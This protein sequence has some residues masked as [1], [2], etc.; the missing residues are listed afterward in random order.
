MTMS[1]GNAYLHELMLHAKQF[2]E[3]NDI[4]N[5]AKLLRRIARSAPDWWE[6]HAELAELYKKQGE[7]KAMLHFAKRSV[8]LHASNPAAWRNL[9]IAATA[10]KKNRIAQ[11]V[12]NKFGI[13]AGKADPRALITL[14]VPSG[15]RFEI[16]WAHPLD[17][18]RAVITSIPQPVSGRRYHDV[19]LFDFEPCGYTVNG[20]KRYAVFDQ[21]G[22]YRH[23]PYKTFSCTVDTTDKKTLRTLERLCREGGLGFENWTNAARVM[24]F[25]SENALP[26]FYGADILPASSGSESVIALAA[27]NQKDAE[28]V[29]RDWSVIT[30]AN[31]SGFQRL[32]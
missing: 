23:S 16:L 30:L 29:L 11:T 15:R 22:L 14:R 18:A 21:L 6:P 3:Q 24:S 32:L 25:Q 2:A 31:F 13:T 12:W 8:A 28:A 1:E 27:L 10:L 17:P 19:L 26:E 20:T 9:G 5:A 4:Y 7:W